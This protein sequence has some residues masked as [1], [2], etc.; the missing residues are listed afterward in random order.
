[1]N[2]MQDSLQRR[3][4]Y[5]YQCYLGDNLLFKNQS[6]LVDEIDKSILM[7]LQKKL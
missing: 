2:F 6:W 1:M 3:R 7:I 5:R 4:Y